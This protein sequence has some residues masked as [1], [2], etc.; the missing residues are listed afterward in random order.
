MQ[1]LETVFVSPV[2]KVIGAVTNM[3]ISVD[4][5]LCSI[6]NDFGQILVIFYRYH[7]ASSVKSVRLYLVSDRGNEN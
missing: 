5:Y 1:S 4:T 7:V 6:N 3:G 2:K